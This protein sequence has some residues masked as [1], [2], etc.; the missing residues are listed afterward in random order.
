TFLPMSAMAD[1]DP[2]RYLEDVEGARSL[3][4]VKAQNAISTKELESDAGYQPLYDRLLAIYDSK[5]R[6]PGI[7][8]IGPWSYNFWRDADH[9]RG[10]MRRTT[11]DEYRKARPRW[12]TVIDVDAIAAAEDE[13]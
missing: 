1:D 5:E 9:V 12:E 8:K 7:A 3:D 10:I 13:N 6:I 11:L 2:Y 4:W